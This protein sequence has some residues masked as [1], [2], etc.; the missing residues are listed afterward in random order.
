MD[1]KIDERMAALL[2]RSAIE[3]AIGHY[4]RGVDRN[5]ADLMRSAFHADAKLTMGTSKNLQ[6]VNQFVAAIQA[7]WQ[8]FRAWGMHYTMN[9]TIDVNGDTAHAET[10]YM[11]LMRVKQ[12]CDQP[13]PYLPKDAGDHPA[14]IWFMGGRYCDRLEK[15]N[16]EWLISF[17]LGNMEWLAPGDGSPSLP[18]L[19]LIG[20][21][22]RRD[23][24]DPSYE[25]PLTR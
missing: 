14:R 1:M 19:Q 11:A 18:M 17:R 2:D 7:G 5:D 9:Q 22:A 6:T 12:G 3:L 13:P 4:A 25:R 8:K 10:Y 23:R 24:S 20:D 21:I 16:G 15:R